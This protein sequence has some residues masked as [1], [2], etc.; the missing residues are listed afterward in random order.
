MPLSSDLQAH[1]WEEVSPTLPAPPD[2]L[3]AL[4]D[5]LPGFAGV[6]A[7]DGVVE[8]ISR[9]ALDLTGQDG[10]AVRGVALVDAPWWSAL[11]Q[12]REQVG[13]ALAAAAGGAA[14]RLHTELGLPHGRVLPVELALLPLRAAGGAMSGLVLRPPSKNFVGLPLNWQG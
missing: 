8:E 13:A 7:P 14:V 2:L 4:F 10:G 6:L 5:A 12:A 11:P 1:D 9:Y 3:P